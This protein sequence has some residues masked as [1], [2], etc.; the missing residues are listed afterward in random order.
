MV[1]DSETWRFA[2]RVLRRGNGTRDCRLCRRRSAMHSIAGL[3]AVTFERSTTIRVR[4]Q[5]RLGSVSAKQSACSTSGLGL[6]A[7]ECFPGLKPG[8]T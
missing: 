2:R 1:D 7:F 6:A 8:S 5:Q 3:A 4:L